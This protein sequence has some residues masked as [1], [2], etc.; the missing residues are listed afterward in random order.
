MTEIELG[1]LLRTATADLPPSRRVDVARA[2]ADGARALRRRRCVASVVSGV[3]VLTLFV[4]TAVVYAAIGSRQPSAPPP[5]IAVG[6]STV[7][8]GA[9]RADRFDV[10]R[11]RVAAGWVPTGMSKEET[12]TYVDRQALTYVKYG[13]EAM[14]VRAAVQQV[15]I[16]VRAAGVPPVP[17]TRPLDVPSSMLGRLASLQPSLGG[18]SGPV[19]GGLTSSWDAFRGEL[20]WQ[21]EPGAWATVA[22]HGAFDVPAEEVA[23]HVAAAIRTDLDQP[24]TMPY[25]VAAPPAPLRLV[26]T[27]V[28]HV[29]NGLYNAQLVF[30][31]RDDQTDPVTLIPRMLLIGVS[32]D[33]RL[34]G[35]G[36][37]GQVNTHIDG[38]PAV[39][40]FDGKG[41]HALLL[42]INGTW[43]EASVYDPVTL[44]YLNQAATVELVRGITVVPK[45]ADPSTW[46]AAPVR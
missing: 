28:T 24:V 11:L 39:V 36:K 27:Q 21:W 17:S 43:A 30:S 46:T 34:I 4:G 32:T 37:V 10:L 9:A 22:V 44:S 38:H 6:P 18:R 15:D 13:P 19:I 40:N 16:T 2:R 31:D 29:G 7:T 5:A 1:D 8:A 25:T 45:P 33:T 42:G 41:G 3:G 23:G 12:D 26:G 20:T 35:D 14:G